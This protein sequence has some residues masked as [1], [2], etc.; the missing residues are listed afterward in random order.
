MLDTTELISRFYEVIRLDYPELPIEEVTKIIR[1]PFIF[2]KEKMKHSNLPEIKF[3][4]F[5]KFKVYP[6]TKAHSIKIYEM[7]QRG[8]NLEEKHNKILIELKLKQ[9]ESQN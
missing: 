6:G 4:F 3:K 8:G 5:G 1:S 7:M 2:L 9:N